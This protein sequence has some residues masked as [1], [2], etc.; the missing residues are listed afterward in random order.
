MS[1]LVNLEHIMNTLDSNVNKNGEVD[2]LSF[3]KNL[4]DDIEQSLGG[5]NDFELSYDDIDNTYRII[6]NTYIANSNKKSHPEFQINT[7]TN[8]KGTFVQDVSIKTE[9]TARIA[10]AIAAGA[11]SNGNTGVSNGTTFAKFT[12]GLT[13]RV[14]TNKQNNNNNGSKNSAYT[15]QALRANELI[16]FVQKHYKSMGPEVTKEDC[17]KFEGIAKDL[18]QYQ[19]GYL[20]NTNEVAGTMFI[21][22]NLQLTVDGISGIK[23]YQSF[24]TNQELLPAEY[25]NKLSFVIKGLSHKINDKGW[26]TTIET[27]AINK[28][29]QSTERP[30][31]QAA[32]IKVETKGKRYTSPMVIVGDER[33]KPIKIIVFKG[34]SNS[35][36]SMYPGTHHA[37]V[38]GGVLATSLTIQQTIDEGRE[39]VNNGVP[40]FDPGDGVG[41]PFGSSA[42]GAYQQLTKYIKDRATA[43][44]LSLTDLYNDINQEKMGENLLDD[45]TN[46]YITGTNKGSIDDLKYAVQMIGQTWSS[47]PIVYANK[48]GSG[49]FGD[50]TTGQGNVGYYGGDGLNPG[51]VSISVGDVVIALIDT[52]KNMVDNSKIGVG[53]LPEFIPTYY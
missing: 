44:G 14:I 11:Q 34:E 21:P 16:A 15:S 31:Y 25:H 45:T 9:L 38:Y 48:F 46:G 27:L 41:K 20:T 1:I 33:L 7:L 47:K 22:L 17:Q 2:V 28:K 26:S 50:V 29:T 3:L 51:T 18:Y 10:N 13:D 23:Q 32:D 43:A 39:R 19:L 4:M 5:I 52:R 36:D 12:D 30:N 24:S 35:Y 8:E 42:I 53:G 37:D 40:G 6:D 49:A